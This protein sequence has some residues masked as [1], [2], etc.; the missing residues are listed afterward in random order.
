[1]PFALPSVTLVID[2]RLYRVLGEGQQPLSLVEAAIDGGVGMV[3]LK[4]TSNGESQIVT[5]ADL[6]ATAVAQRLREMTSDQ[7]PFLVTGDIELADRSKAD[8]IVLIGDKTYRPDDAR[9]Y[10]KSTAVVGC[11]VDTL[12]AAALAEHGGADFVQIGPIFENP[13]DTCLTLIRK[14]KDAVNIPVLAYGGID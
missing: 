7:V 14:V 6:V 12:R 3:Q 4:L 10:L 1:M 5:P 9:E 13:D 11:Y 2:R 8:G